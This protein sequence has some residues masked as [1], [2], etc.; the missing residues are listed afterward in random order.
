MANRSGINLTWYQVILIC[1]IIFGAFG[2]SFIRADEQQSAAIKAIAQEVKKEIDTENAKQDKVISCKLDTTNFKQYTTAH[3]AEYLGLVKEF[4]E[5]KKQVQDSEKQMIE[6]I[7]E[8]E[9]EIIR[10][11]T[12]MKMKGQ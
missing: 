8:S 12:T 2:S 11:L 6:R 9:K 3:N 4:H 1:V 5:V 10:I 7:N